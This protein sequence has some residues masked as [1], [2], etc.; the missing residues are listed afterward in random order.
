VRERETGGEGE[1]LAALA[2]EQGEREKD[3]GGGHRERA[4]PAR[5]RAAGKC[6]ALVGRIR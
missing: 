1:S 3:R 6:W 2:R 5:V 4:R